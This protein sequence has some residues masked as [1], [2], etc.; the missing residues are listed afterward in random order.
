MLE[1]F[2]ALLKFALYAGVLSGSGAVLAQA[3]LRP[4]PEEALYLQKVARWGSA[5]VLAACPLLTLVLILRLGGELDEATL[6]AVFHSASGAALFLQLTGAV[7]LLT[8]GDDEGSILLRLSYALLPLLSFAFSGHAAAVGPGEGLVAA[9][10]VSVAAWWLGS[11]HFLRERCAHAEFARVAALVTR[12]S[13]MAFI[14]AGTLVIAGLFLIL[15][16]VDF[17]TDPWLTPYGWILGAKLCVVGPLLA[18]AGYN[19]RQ[20]TPRLVAGDPSAASALRSSINA[21]VALIAVVL[22]ITAILTTYTS[23]PE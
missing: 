1:A 15:I 14:L 2:T 21:E 17:S 7:L 8:S 9:L 3:T 11:L 5:V 4:A 19:R 6:S 10:H 13:A 16:L 20:L 22:A 12:F 18:V 23:P